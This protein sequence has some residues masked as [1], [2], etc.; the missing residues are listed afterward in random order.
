MCIERARTQ[1]TALLMYASDYDGT[2]PPGPLWMDQ[3]T[4]YVFPLLV[5]FTCPVLE[6]NGPGEYGFG[7]HS[8]ILGE[9]VVSFTDPSVVITVFEVESAA[10]NEVGTEAQMLQ[11][12]R[13]FGVVTVARLDG[14]SRGEAP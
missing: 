3:I 1:N 8:Q 4:P 13:H 5:N 6:Q 14:S 7:L 12:P 10:K 9:T 11:A 2:L